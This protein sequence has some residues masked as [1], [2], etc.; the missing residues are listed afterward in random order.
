M[1]YSY[2]S[3]RKTDMGEEKSEV[4]L[5]KNGYKYLISIMKQFESE[6]VCSVNKDRVKRS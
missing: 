5:T 4:I 6:W 3:T 2:T 1:E